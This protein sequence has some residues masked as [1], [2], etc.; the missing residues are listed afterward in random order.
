MAEFV[1]G[2]ELSR[3]FYEEV[4]ADAIVGV[5]HAAALLGT[6]SDVLGLDTP[7]STDHGWGPRLEL[8]VA[9]EDLAAV[10]ERVDALLPA[11]FKGWPTRYGWDDV[12]VSHHVE[13]AVL[14]DWLLEHIGFDPR[15]GARLVDWLS[16]PQQ[17]L[18]ELTGGAVHRD[19]TGAL[20]SVRAALGW[21]PEPVW[22]WLLACQW[23]RLDQEEPFVGRAAE[24]GDEPGS[25]IVGAR[26]ARDLIRLCFLLERRYAP[27][28]KWLG[29]CFQRLRS[30]PLVGPPL[31]EALRADG[32]PERE[33]ALGRAFRAVASLHNAVGATDPV[34]DRL[35]P[36]HGR[37]FLVLGSGRFVEACLDRV[38]DARLRALPL[39]GA[40][41][42]LA[43]SADA[44]SEPAALPA[45]RA[46]YE[47]WLD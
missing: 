2:L 6:G 22:L 4:V 37:P 20:R 28:S 10:R 1:P 17:R 19:D 15:D 11:T 7:R 33:D 25:R 38:E 47:T 40:V 32:Y 26:L 35:R 31:V 8:F 24:V 41:D 46:L 39:V 29:S 43:D 3:S 23:R 16:T 12:P 5:P 21:Y 42:Q 36:F 9:E 14:R 27:Y 45:V 34:D 13:T 44:L 30:Y 18:L